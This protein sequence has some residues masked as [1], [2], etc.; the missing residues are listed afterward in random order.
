[1]SNLTEYGGGPV[2]EAAFDAAFDALGKQHLEAVWHPRDEY[3][4]VFNRT[5]QIGSATTP[6]QAGELFA[7]AIKE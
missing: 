5:I 7:K 4:A 1:M 3:L 2:L 6:R